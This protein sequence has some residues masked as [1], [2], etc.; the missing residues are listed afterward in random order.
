MD[1]IPACKWSQIQIL[2]KLAWMGSSEMSLK[3]TCL[4]YSERV[5][6]GKALTTESLTTVETNERS[7]GS[8]LLFAVF[9]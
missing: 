1:Q 7:T 4:S 5:L 3:Y 9:K 8:T 6:C 2:K